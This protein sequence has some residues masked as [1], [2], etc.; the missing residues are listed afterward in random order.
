MC[1]DKRSILWFGTLAGLAG[2]G[3][4]SSA[5]PPSTTFTVD[6]IL[7]RCVAAYEGARTL[8]VRGLFR[9][10]RGQTRRVANIA[11]DFAR[12]NRCRLQIEMDAAL[13]VGENW[14]VYDSEARRYRQHAQFTRTP[15]ETAAYL[16]S[17][18]VPFLLPELMTKGAQAFGGTRSGRFVGW[19]LEGFEWHAERPCYLLARGSRGG[20]QATSLR[21]WIDQ[22]RFVIRG[23]ALLAAAPDGREAVVMGCSY[24][25]ILVNETLPPD[26]FDLQPPKEIILSLPTTP[27]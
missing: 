17:K 8:Q 5:P 9:D 1:I 16:L 2:C 10:Y 19:R 4:P 13:V 18:G 25:D 11:W 24:F 7:G 20:E 27:P 26:R 15:M 12:P 6:D 22:D 23:W 3:N 21:V 14:W